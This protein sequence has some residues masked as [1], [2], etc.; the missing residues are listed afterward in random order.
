MA[1]C[2]AA[3]NFSRCSTAR[4]GKALATIDYVPAR[5]TV[6]SWGDNYGNRVDRFLGGVAYLDGRHPSLIIE[7]RL[8]HAHSDRWLGIGNM[9]SSR[10]AGCS[11]R[12]SRARSIAGQGNHQLAV[13]DVDNDG[14]DEIVFGAMTVDDNGTALYNTAL[15]H[16]DALHVGD[17]DP[18][19]PGARSVQSH[20]VAH[21]TLWSCCLGCR[22]RRD[23]MG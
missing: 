7:S 8:L 11:I 4:A 22:D 5:G 20:G 23:P 2:S 3:P 9:A 17:L 1:T 12:T 14:K 18:A 16:G 6:E 21:V 19:R 10:S 15:G 13:A